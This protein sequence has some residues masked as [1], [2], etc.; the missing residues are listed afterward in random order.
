MTSVTTYRASLQF[1]IDDGHFGISGVSVNE[2]RS[3]IAGS[4]SL[5]EMTENRKGI[6]LKQGCASRGPGVRQQKRDISGVSPHFHW[7]NQCIFLMAGPGTNSWLQSIPEID[8]F[9]VDPTNSRATN[10]ANRKPVRKADKT[11]YE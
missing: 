9:V 5:I 2:R 6:T 11:A 7:W 4:L 10:R 1:R 3:R 8:N